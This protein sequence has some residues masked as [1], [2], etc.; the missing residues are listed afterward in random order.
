MGKVRFILLFVLLFVL[1]TPAFAYSVQYVHKGM[2]SFTPEEGE[3]VG[4]WTIFKDDNSNIFITTNVS[5]NAVILQRLSGSGR[6]DIGSPLYQR[7]ALYDLSVTTTYDFG[8]LFLSRTG[9][10]YPVIPFAGVTYTYKYSEINIFG[11]LKVA[12]P[13]SMVMPESSLGIIKNGFLDVA[14]GFGTD[15]KLSGLSVLTSFMY[16][17]NYNRYSFS[18]GACALK[19]EKHEYRFGFNIGFGVTI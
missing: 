8:G 2:V 13:F 5:D 3:K 14:A 1:C 19:S 9:T 10:F 16:R 15:S 18:A 11:G 7:P 12:I 6:Y 4:K 17:Y